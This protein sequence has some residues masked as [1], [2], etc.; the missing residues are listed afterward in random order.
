MW[1]MFGQTCADS[2]IILTFRKRTA[3]SQTS[4]KSMEKRE[5]ADLKKEVRTRYLKL[6]DQIP[7]DVKHERFNR[8]V[9]V[10]NTI[11]AEKNAAYVGRIEK[12]LVDGPSKTNSKTYGGRTETFKLVNFRGSPEMT[13]KIVNVRITAS[14]TFSLEGEVVSE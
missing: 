12:V 11:S 3:A 1:Q 7:E 14:N 5:Q 10:I 2:S 6:R 4:E 9:D 13:G 8:L